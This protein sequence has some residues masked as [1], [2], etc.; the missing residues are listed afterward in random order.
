MSSAVS[1]LGTSTA[2]TTAPGAGINSMTASDFLNLMIQQL[3]QQDPLNPTDSNQLLT[4]MSQIGS[5]QSNTQLQ[6]TLTQMG[7]Q[8]SIGASGNLIGKTVSGV[9]TNGK[10]VQG[11]VTSIKVVN[12]QVNL[13]LDSGGGEIAM[14]N[15]ISVATAGAATPGAA[16]PS[17]ASATSAA[18]AMAAALTQPTTAN[19]ATTSGSS[20]TSA[21]ASLLAS[22]LS[23]S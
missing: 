16:L 4:Q 3:Q 18:S 10:N 15:V 7:L 11:T 21:I 5:L 2:G 20:S 22:K 23:G 12:Q 9:G 6:Q 8:Q 19:S 17:A 1:S 14:N 13:E